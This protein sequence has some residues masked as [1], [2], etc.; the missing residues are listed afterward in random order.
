MHTGGWPYQEPFWQIKRINP[1]YTLEQLYTTTGA[2][3]ES[4]ATH[5]LLL[6]TLGGFPHES[7]DATERGS[8][9]TEVHEYI[10]TMHV[11]AFII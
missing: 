6:S 3:L 10:F 2:P 9:E 8:G 4:V 7:E 11:Y 1:L 5:A